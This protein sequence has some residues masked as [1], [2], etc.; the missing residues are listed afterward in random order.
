MRRLLVLGLG[1]TAERFVALHGGLFG[2][3]AATVRTAAKADAK[4]RSGLRVFAFDGTEAPCAALTEAVQAAS[5]VLVSIPPSR[6]KSGDPGLQL[7]EGACGAGGGTRWIGYLST[8]GVYGDHA[9]AWIDEDTPAT[10]MQARSARRLEAENAW[11]ALAERCGAAVQVF[12]LPG[13]YGPGRNAL[14]DLQAGSARRLH[15]EGQVFNRAHVD[16]IA[17]AIAAGIEHPRIGPVINVVDNEP[18]PQ[19]AVVAYA[20]RLLGI[21]PPPLVA[22]DEAEISEMARSFWAE[23]KRVGNRRLRNELGVGLAFPTFRQGLDAIHRDAM[24]EM[25]RS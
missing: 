5:H 20:A 12:R 18:A 11:R 17:A 4:S 23:N 1:Y 13:I 8:I 15:K 25:S 3:V 10:P 14:A 2:D 6:E 16:D 24:R 7:V 22:F 9:G 21:E 19:E